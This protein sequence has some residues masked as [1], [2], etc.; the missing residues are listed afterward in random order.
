MK[1]KLTK[2]HLNALFSGANMLVNMS[3]VEKRDDEYSII[4]PI[5]AA[6]AR[7]L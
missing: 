2:L 7:T 4:D 6:A 3:I 5:Y 1:T